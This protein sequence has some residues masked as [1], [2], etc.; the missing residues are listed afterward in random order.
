MG[1]QK[2][3][4]VILMCEH[5]NVKVVGEAHIY[6]CPMPIMIRECQDCGGINLGQFGNYYESWDGQSHWS[7]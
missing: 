5:K 4:G 3:K 2:C 6:K 1:I 7:D